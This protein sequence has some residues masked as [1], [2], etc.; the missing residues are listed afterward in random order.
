M[1]PSSD[2]T[3]ALTAL[4]GRLSG[5]AVTALHRG[6]QGGNNRLYRAETA[7]GPLAVKCYFRHPG[8]SRDRLAVEFAALG[9]LGGHGI[10]CIPKAI[11]AAAEDGVAVY[12]WLSGAKLEQRQPGDMERMAAFL[13]QV[14]GLAAIPAARALPLASEACLS[15]A[16]L[17]SQLQRRVARLGEGAAG[18]SPAFA[19]FLT[20]ELAPAVAAMKALADPAEL[21]WPRRTLSPSD[22]GTH[23][24][25]RRAD[26]GLDFL[27]FEYFGWD[28]PVKLV[29][30]T[31]L[32]PGMD[33]SADERR[34]FHAAALAIYGG[35]PDFAPRLARLTPLY[36]LRWALIVLNPFLPERWARTAFATGADR[37]AVLDRQLGKAKRF[38]AIAME[39]I[40]GE[41]LFIL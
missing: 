40:D 2:D 27:D 15:S 5:H 9:F 6:G 7:H 30:D 36:A 13:A 19:R 29:A 38:V 26:G 16:E 21:D 31:L 28:D 37:Q 24:A 10:T 41:R 32:H 3:A 18:G 25:L 14:H 11:A 8:D 23:N 34:Q 12:S 22:F 39:K 1:T 35:D 17:V 20:A 33:L 4:V